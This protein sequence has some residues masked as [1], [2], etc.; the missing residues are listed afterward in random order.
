[1][2]STSPPLSFTWSSDSSRPS[3]GVYHLSSF[4]GWRESLVR[5]TVTEAFSLAP[6]VAFAV[7][8][9]T[10]TSR[11]ASSCAPWASSS[12]LAVVSSPGTPQ[13]P[14]RDAPTTAIH[15]KLPRRFLLI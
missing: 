3:A 10:D 5:V 13:A 2:N 6:K 7:D 14:R 12:P 15:L 11:A 1:M 8:S 9:R 4:T